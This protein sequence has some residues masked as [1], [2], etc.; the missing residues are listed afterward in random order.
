M[1]VFNAFIMF[2][3]LQKDH[4]G[5]KQLKRHKQYAQI[6]IK[7]ELTKELAFIK[8]DDTPHL[9]QFE[10]SPRMASHLPVVAEN[11]LRCFVCSHEGRDL[12]TIFRCEKCNLPLCVT[13]E[14]NCF[15]RYHSKA[16]HQG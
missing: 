4:P 14:R 10:A 6:D 16:Y 13:R 1:A 5:D 11:R 3:A 2:A 12:K 15:K 9:Y 7:I 8:D